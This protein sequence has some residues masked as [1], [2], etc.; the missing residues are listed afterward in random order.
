MLGR[1]GLLLWNRFQCSTGSN[2][3][4]IA[5]GVASAV[6]LPREQEGLRET[7]V[8][9]L[10]I[11]NLVDLLLSQLDTERLDV[12]FEVFNLSSTDDWENMLQTISML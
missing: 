2:H 9:V 12:T 11:F 4:N 6:W 8:K 10:R 5:C 7:H 1:N 3:W